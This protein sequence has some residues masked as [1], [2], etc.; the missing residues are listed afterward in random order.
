MRSIRA[1]TTASV[2]VRP[3]VGL[4]LALV[5]LHDSHH[6]LDGGAQSEEQSEVHDPVCV[7]LAIQKVP[8]TAPEHEAENYLDSEGPGAAR[9][10]PEFFAIRVDGAAFV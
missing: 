10:A 7:E 1:S 3:I 5:L 6:P 8:D 2:L 4:D 9:R